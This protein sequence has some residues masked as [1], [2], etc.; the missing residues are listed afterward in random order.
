MSKYWVLTGQ[1]TS[2][3]CPVNTRPRPWLCSRDS[4]GQSNQE[5]NS[6][7]YLPSTLESNGQSKGE[8]GEDS[9][10]DGNGWSDR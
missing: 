6:E 5:S 4:K 3:V 1:F 2:L 8:C 9:N 7:S 10:S